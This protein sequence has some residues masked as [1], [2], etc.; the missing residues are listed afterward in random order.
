MAFGTA[1][2]SFYRD[3]DQFTLKGGGREEYLFLYGFCLYCFIVIVTAGET[4][5]TK[6]N[7]SIIYNSANTAVTCQNV[8][9]KDYSVTLTTAAYQPTVFV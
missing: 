7:S 2:T 6:W 5:T 1:E 3:F 9:N 4:E 8:T